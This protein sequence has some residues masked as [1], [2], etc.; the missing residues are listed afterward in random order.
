MINKKNY[1]IYCEEYRKERILKYIDREIKKIENNKNKT[2][3]KTNLELIFLKK[4]RKR[5]L[6]EVL[7]NKEILKEVKN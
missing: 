2:K 6:K 5:L 3:N 1:K 7:K 4:W